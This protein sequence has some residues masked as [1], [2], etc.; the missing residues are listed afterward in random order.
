VERGELDLT[1]AMFPLP[2]GPFGSVELLSDPYVLMVPMESPLARRKD[3][4]L[5]T[6][7]ADEPLIGAKECRS[8]LRAETSMSAFGLRPRLVFESDDNDT[9]QSLVAAGVGL[10]LRPLLA[11]DTNDHRIAVLEITPPLPRRVIALAWH[12][13]RYR[14]PA[15]EAFVEATVAFCAELGREHHVLAA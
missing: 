2:E 15:A 8:W 14:A 10:A 6:E 3:P 12:R 5:L 1:F 4:V 9:V 7:L 13:D 11:V